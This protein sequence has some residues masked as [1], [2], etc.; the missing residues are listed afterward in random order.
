MDE[1]GRGSWA[2]PVVAAAV[3]LPKKL[4]LPGLDDSKKLTVQQ[5]ELLFPKICSTCP[6][7]IGVASAEEVDEKGLLQATFLAFSRALVQLEAPADH[8]YIDGRDAF[9]FS[10][11]HTSVIRGDGIYRC[12]AA[13]SILAKVTRDRLMVEWASRFPLYGFEFH[14]GYGTARHQ[15]ALQ[16]HGPCDL[17]RKTY[18]PLQNL[19]CLQESFL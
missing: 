13:A 11:P 15:R 5:R 17:H 2:G 1:V 12:I 7:G 14:K 6:H 3:I 10:L 18:K 4:R 19:K 8:I 9:H 16:E